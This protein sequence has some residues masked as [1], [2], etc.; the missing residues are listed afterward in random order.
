MKMIS[1]SSM[2]KMSETLLYYAKRVNDSR[3]RGRYD[4]AS[5]WLSMLLGAL[6]I[7]N[8]LAVVQF[9]V[10]EMRDGTIELA[11]IQG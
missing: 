11:R 2:Q 3:K 1:D 6:S 8:E 10:D 9:T 4:Y 7:Y 5:D